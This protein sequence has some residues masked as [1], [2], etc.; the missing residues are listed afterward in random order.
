MR[1]WIVFAVVIMMITPLTVAGAAGAAGAAEST[2]RSIGSACPREL[3][4]DGF[5][6]VTTSN[7][8]EFAIDCVTFWGVARGTA[9][10]RYSP[11]RTVT[12]AEM[13]TFVA[14]ALERT[15]V[16]LPRT[17][18]DAFDDDDHQTAHEANI[19][20]LAAAGI[21]AGVA[22]GRYAPQ[23][24]VTRAQMATFLLG[25]VTYATA[26]DPDTT[27]DAFDDDDGNAH[28]ASINGAATLG[29][30]TGTGARRYGVAQAV[31]RDQMGHGPESGRTPQHRVPELV[32][33]ALLLQ[34]AIAP[35]WHSSHVALAGD[36]L[37]HDTAHLDDG[38]GQSTRQFDR[39]RIP[40]R[41]E[42][43]ATL[44][45]CE[46]Q[47]GMHRCSAETPRASE[48]VRLAERVEQRVLDHVLGQQR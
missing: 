18:A 39:V 24:R 46:R 22:D 27:V 37:R 13:A 15:T 21:V 10:R 2:A 33:R 14:R 34:V 23:R 38:C 28:E 8:H 42:H 48:V 26:V 3:P 36:L 20:A 43:G 1:R 7:T 40:G 47:H 9:P 41:V 31:R 12:R 17:N 6:D 5:S 45:V 30:A 35:R 44:L 11:G 25:A 19:N 32:R 29:L 4:D 16:G